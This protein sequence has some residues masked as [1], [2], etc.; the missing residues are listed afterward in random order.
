MWQFTILTNLDNQKHT[1][2]FLALAYLADDHVK[3]AK[4]T[5]EK[6]LDLFANFEPDHAQDPVKF[7]KLAEEAKRN[8]PSLKK[9]PVKKWPWFVGGIIIAGV[10]TALLTRPPAAKPLPGP[11]TV[12]DNN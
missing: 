9:N 6:L 2:S 11:P 1:H 12:G 10:A 5:I 3:E 8:R 7:I 4:V